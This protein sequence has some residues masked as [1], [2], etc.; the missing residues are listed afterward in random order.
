MSQF[1]A[2]HDHYA[3]LRTIIAA[4]RGRICAGGGGASE[5]LKPAPVHEAILSDLA[6]LQT[7]VES[8]ST[9]KY[10]DWPTCETYRHLLYATAAACVAADEAETT[11]S[12][13]G[14]PSSFV[15]R[16]IADDL[17]GIL[18]RVRGAILDAGARA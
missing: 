3:A 12:Q 18:L 5:V 9:L 13:P 1:T 8:P 6:E 17:V 10:G 4:R 7:G 14:E 11:S 2:T 15:A 16:Q